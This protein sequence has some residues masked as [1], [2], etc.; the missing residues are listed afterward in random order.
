M[1]VLFRVTGAD[2]D[3][4]VVVTGTSEFDGFATLIDASADEVSA[5]GRVVAPATRVVEVV[6]V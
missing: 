3:T 2:V 1:L 5:T 4:D 6:V